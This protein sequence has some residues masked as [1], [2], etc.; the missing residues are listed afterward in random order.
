LSQIPAPSRA[1]VLLLVVAV[2]VVAVSS[3]TIV[4]GDYVSRIMRKCKK[5][6]K[7]KREGKQVSRILRHKRIKRTITP[8]SSFLTLSIIVRPDKLLRTR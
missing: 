4:L 6:K 7:D 2:V 1:S 5:R 3:L 8:S